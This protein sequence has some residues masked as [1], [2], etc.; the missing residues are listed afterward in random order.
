MSNPRRALIVGCGKI[1]GG[2]NRGPSDT[3]I[4]THALAY[5]RHPEYELVADLT[6]V[7]LR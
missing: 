4:L 6:T 2:Y 1:A 5:L 7:S 3:K